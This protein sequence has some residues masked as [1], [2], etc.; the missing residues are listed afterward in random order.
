MSHLCTHVL[1]QFEDGSLSVQKVDDIDKFDCL[2]PPPIDS[3]CQIWW[4]VNGKKNKKA[5]K[6]A[7]TV[8]RYGGKYVV[9]LT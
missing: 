1:V 4:K 8:L 6:F 2:N 7:A 3:E 5:E 9:L